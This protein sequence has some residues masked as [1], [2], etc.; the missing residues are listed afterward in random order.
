VTC[1]FILLCFECKTKQ[2]LCSLIVDYCLARLDVLYDPWPEL[3]VLADNL[4]P[5]VAEDGPAHR[6]HASQL[7]ASHESHGTT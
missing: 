7:D 6:C 2:S 1:Q 4:G 5:R 3:A